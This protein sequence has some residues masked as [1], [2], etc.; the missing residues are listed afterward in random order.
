MAR[1]MR[2]DTIAGLSAGIAVI[3]LTGNL[4]VGIVIGLAAFLV[5]L[6]LKRAF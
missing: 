5:A 4:L 1:K 3:V 2:A 6:I